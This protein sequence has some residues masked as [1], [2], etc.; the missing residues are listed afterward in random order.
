MLTGISA[1]D[2]TGVSE[3]EWPRKLSP[4]HR[5]TYDERVAGLGYPMFRH[6]IKHY[7]MRMQGCVS[8]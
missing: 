1:T 7:I 5:A 8:I 4:F 6:I 2:T 3:G